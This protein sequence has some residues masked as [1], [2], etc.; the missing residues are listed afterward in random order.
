MD[1]YDWLNA[2]HG[3]GLMNLPSGAKEW[4]ANNKLHRLDGPAVIEKNYE[5]WYV[6]GERHRSDGP[7]RIWSQDFPDALLKGK[8]EWWLNGKKCSQK[9][10]HVLTTGSIKNLPLYMHQGFDD[11]IELRLKNEKP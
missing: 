2:H 5:A 7:A 4:Y 9:M 11:I 10:H 1:R 8:K 6:G 3:T